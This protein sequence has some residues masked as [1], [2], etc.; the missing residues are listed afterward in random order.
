MLF[1]CAPDSFKE[2]M[3]ATVAAHAM[4]RGIL[5]VFP[6][7]SVILKPM[8]DGGEGTCATIASAMGIHTRSVGCHDALGRPTD[9]RIA[10]VTEQDL[11]VIEVAESCGLEKLA[12]DERDPRHTTSRGVGELILAGLNLGARSLI[13]GLGGSAT[14]DAGVGMLTALGARFLDVKGVEIPPGGAAL[15]DLAS[16]DLE[17]LDPR[18]AGITVRVA[19]DVDSP[20]TGHNGASA[21]FGPQKGASPDDVVVLDAALK[22]WADV[23]EGT[24]HRKV[25]DAPGAGAAGGLGAA[26][27]AFFDAVIESGADLVLDVIALSE[28]LPGATAVFTGEGSLDRQ[29]TAGKVP[30]RVAER[31]HSYGVPTVVFAGRIDPELAEHPPRGVAATVPIVRDLVGLPEALR[32]GEENLER[33]VAMTCQLL[34][35]GNRLN[36]EV[37]AQ[38]AQR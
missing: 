35:A 20:L 16:V 18:L 26:L 1:I 12:A 38:N 3:S 5:R 34:A 28:H 15:A 32:M 11:A 14:N 8:A 10:Y 7:A 27:L 17:G 9:G 37:M 4:K 30:L 22:R 21:V 31:A 36:D 33:A 2:S 25:R 29:S 13:V 24:V 19:S 6:D 23:V